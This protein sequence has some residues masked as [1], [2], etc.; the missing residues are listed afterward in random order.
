MKG[1][2]VRCAGGIQVQPRW[3]G[4]SS[5][6]DNAWPCGDDGWDK[7]I[8]NEIQRMRGEHSKGGN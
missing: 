5:T 3:G 6:S 8:D 4:G 1:E 2:S 7:A